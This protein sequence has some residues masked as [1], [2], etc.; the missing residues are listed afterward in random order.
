MYIAYLCL[1]L[2]SASYFSFICMCGSAHDCG[3]MVDGSNAMAASWILLLLLSNFIN[4]YLL[5]TS[6][7]PFVRASFSKCIC[8]CIVLCTC[9][10]TLVWISCT[11]N[12][13]WGYYLQDYK[14]LSQHWL[15]TWT[16][17]PH[18]VLVMLA[19]YSK[20][21]PKALLLLYYKIYIIYHNNDHWCIKI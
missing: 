10:C 11:D 16:L 3:C 12:S 20:V 17:T 7:G 18:V 8:W 4:F 6:H 14:I 13:A 21:L 19:R 2:V 15:L 1:N 5:A 9:T